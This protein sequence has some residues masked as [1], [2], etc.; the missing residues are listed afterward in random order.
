MTILAIGAHPDDLDYGASGTIAKWVKE[1]AKAYYLVATD[2]SKGCVNDEILT[3]QLIKIRR[4]EQESACRILGVE[5]V[6]FLSH[7]DGEL[8]NSLAL[9][10]EIARVIRHTKPDIVIT[11]DP[12]F[13]YCVKDGFVNHPDHRAVGQA[14]LDAI[15][16]FAR[17]ARA[18]PELLNEGFKPHKV[19]QV[20]LLNFNVHNYY[21][22]ISSS[23]DLKIKALE[24]HKTQHQ[25]IDKMK[26]E[27]Q[28]E[29]SEFGKYASC[30]Y[31]EGFV[32]IEID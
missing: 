21:V 5:K 17:D 29:A 22:D 20:M 18:F 11:I 2:G 24:Q 10:K 6:F 16:P 12:T 31:A 1:G 9:R 7:I 3:E 14:S 32:K 13:V 26:Q 25:S 27:V 28:D 15:Y 4:Q 19:K 30:Q 23:L 8:E